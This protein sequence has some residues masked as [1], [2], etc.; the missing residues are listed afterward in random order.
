MIYILLQGVCQINST[1]YIMH[2]FIR[3]FRKNHI[4]YILYCYTANYKGARICSGTA[5]SIYIFNANFK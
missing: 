3:K 2:T 5:C 1:Y 4:F